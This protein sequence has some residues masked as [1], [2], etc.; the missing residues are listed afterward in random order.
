VTDV[1]LIEDGDAAHRPLRRFLLAHVPVGHE[2]EPVGIGRD[3][4]EDD[5]VEDAPGLGVVPADHP[6]DELDELLG[7]QDLRR[8]EPAVDPDHGLALG[9]EPARDIVGQALSQGQA[10]RNVLDPGQAGVVRR[11][12][13]DGHDHRPALGRYPDLDDPHPVGFGVELFPIG[14][15]LFVIDELVVVADRETELLFRARDLGRGRREAERHREAEEQERGRRDP[16]S[17]TEAGCH[18]QGAPSS[19]EFG[20]RFITEDGRDCQKPPGRGRITT[21]RG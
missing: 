2:V 1:L 11:R 7:A 20:K 15:E 6:P 9:G 16:L 14:G 10:R 19:M 12:R 18:G 17:G 3:R 4:E 5:V 8:V 21:R 13:D